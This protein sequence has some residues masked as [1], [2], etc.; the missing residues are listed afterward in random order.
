ML[1]SFIAPDSSSF[2]RR[3]RGMAASN[4]AFFN[5]AVCCQYLISVGTICDETRKL[6]LHRHTRSLQKMDIETA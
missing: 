3:S 6:D 2:M 5:E 4:D 1:L